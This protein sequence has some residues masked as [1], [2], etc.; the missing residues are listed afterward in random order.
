MARILV[1]SNGD[2]LV[3]LSTDYEIRDIYYPLVGQENHA[4][5]LASHF[6]FG[7]DGE[8]SW[9]NSPE[10]QRSLH[11]E[12]E[13]LVTQ[14]AA[15]NPHLQLQVDISEAVDIGRP[16]YLRRVVAHN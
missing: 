4:M 3:N 8:F 6:G 9:I 11:Y 7:V 12:P 16:V 14:V 5:G 13:T 2:M 1:T 10:W 15:S